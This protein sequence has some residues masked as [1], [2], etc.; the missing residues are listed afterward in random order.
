MVSVKPGVQPKLI[1]L[2]TAVANVAQRLGLHLTITSGIDGTHAANSLH[3]SL[4]ALDVRSKDVPDPG[5]LRLE[6]AKELGPDYQVILESPNKP[7]QHIHLE[8]DPK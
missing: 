4:R 3:Y 7:N 8:F 5:K 1:Y 6:L 2:V